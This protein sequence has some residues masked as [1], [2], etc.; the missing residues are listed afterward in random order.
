VNSRPIPT[1]AEPE[2][3][4]LHVLL[5]DADGEREEQQHQY[6]DGDSDPHD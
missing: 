4:A 5:D 1:A 6:D 3:H 2:E